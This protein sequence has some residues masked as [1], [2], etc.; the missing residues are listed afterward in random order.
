MKPNPKSNVLDVGLVDVEVSDTQSALR[1]DPEALASVARGALVAEGIARAS[2]S[3]AVVDDR[4][5]RALNARHLGHDWPTDVIS[6]LL[7]GPRDGVLS[8]EIVV[9]AETAA[10]TAEAAGVPPFDEL[11]LYVVHGLLHLCGYDD[12]D[13]LTRVAM[14]RREGQVLARLGLSYTFPALASADAGARERARWTD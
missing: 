12:G 1:F 14:R 5:I 7:S 11:A 9:S 8:G 2:V 13:D 6:F 10:R 3:L 4:A